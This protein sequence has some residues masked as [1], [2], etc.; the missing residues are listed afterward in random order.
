MIQVSNSVASLWEDDARWLN[1]KIYNYSGSAWV[2]VENEIQSFTVTKGVMSDSE[3]ELGGTICP[4]ASITLFGS[5]APSSTRL[6]RIDIGIDVG[7]T[8]VDEVYTPSFSYITLGSFYVDKVETN[9]HETHI[10]CTSEVIGR[11]GGQTI[12]VSTK[13]SADIVTNVASK[14]GLTIGNPLGV[15]STQLESAVSNKTCREALSIVAKTFGGAVYERYTTSATVSLV[16]PFTVDASNILDVSEDR[17]EQDFMSTGD[18]VLDSV[19]VVVSNTDTPVVKTFGSE[20]YDYQMENE[21]MS[22]GTFAKFQTN[23]KDKGYVSGTLSMLMGDARI[24]PMDR[25]NLYH[26]EDDEKVYSVAV[27]VFSVEHRFDGGLTTTI[28]A[29]TPQ[30]YSSLVDSNSKKLSSVAGK[31]NDVENRVVEQDDELNSI[32]TRVGNFENAMDG[33]VST[34]LVKGDITTGSV[35]WVADDNSL[36]IVGTNEGGSE[37]YETV[38]GGDGIKF[39]YNGSVVASIDQDKLVIDKTI[40]FTS[41][42]VGNWKWEVANNDNLTL[43]WAKTEEGGN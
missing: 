10:D 31:I 34:S 23:V 26:Y 30:D 33:K 39:K 11:L 18:I 8:T 42:Q 12:D 24:E 9:P 25:I 17:L 3:F 14:F 4:S 20:P 7:G 43:K 29:P 38:V 22:D 6:L 40:L 16:N 28:Y 15:D 5:Y 36:H 2:E 32:A 21:Y 13:V 19:K 27:P 1:A 35:E 41:M 37:T